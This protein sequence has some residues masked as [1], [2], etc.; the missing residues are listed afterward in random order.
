MCES[1]RPDQ[2]NEQ[3]ANDKDDVIEPNHIHQ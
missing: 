1:K 3:P 2:R